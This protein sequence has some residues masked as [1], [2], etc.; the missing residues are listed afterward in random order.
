[1]DYK[2]C[3]LH[4]TDSNSII[5]VDKVETIADYLPISFLSLRE[6]ASKLEPQTHLD[7]DTLYANL[8]MNTCGFL[9]FNTSASKFS[10]MMLKNVTEEEVEED[11]SES[12]E[13][14]WEE[15]LL[16]DQYRSTQ[17]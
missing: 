12:E 9:D 4:Q 14:G 7:T 1:M 17:T 2:T 5:V 10:L 11:G 13:D 3:V 8:I 6:T 16:S 15:V